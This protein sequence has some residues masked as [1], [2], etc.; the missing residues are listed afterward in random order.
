MRWYSNGALRLRAGAGLL[1]TIALADYAVA[2]ELT[3]VSSPFSRF[4]FRPY[5][6][7]LDP[8][9]NRIYWA[10]RSSSTGAIESAPLDGAVDCP[11][12][13]SLPGPLV[14]AI[15]PAGFMYVP[16]GSR[17]QRLKLLT[18]P[19]PCPT[20]VVG[21]DVVT[22]V[23]LGQPQGIA[24]GGGWIYWTDSAAGKIQ[25]APLG[26]NSP[27]ACGGAQCDVLTGL[28]TPQNVAIDVTN[29][30]ISWT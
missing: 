27:T 8:A 22:G 19:S 29:G 13:F 28:T 9:N 6:I 30:H 7:A 4:Q 21:E 14:F 10:D 3:N 1:A 12:Y 25:R 17:I 23:S 24:V 16:V 15:D 5:N 2:L 18:G 20:T 11:N 26:T